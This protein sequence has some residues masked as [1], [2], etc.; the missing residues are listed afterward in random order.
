VKLA[1]NS[2]TKPVYRSSG[3]RG[4]SP[5]VSNDPRRVDARKFEREVSV[6]FA[7]K[8]SI[9]Q[10]TEGEVHVKTGDAVITG[11]HGEHWRVSRNHFPDKYHP[12]P[13]T[14]M[15]ESGRYA[16]KRYQILAVPMTEAFQ[17]WLADGVSCLSGRSGDWLVDYGDGSLG[18]VAGAVFATT[19]EVLPR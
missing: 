3:Q 14:V 15:G 4:F 17:V 19:Y 16:S 11:A 10:T 1:L 6:R 5:Y 18:V 9:L 8:P 7:A 2:A 12:V 13:P